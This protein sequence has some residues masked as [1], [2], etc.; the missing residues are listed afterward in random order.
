VNS[1]RRLRL[2]AYPEKYGDTGI[3]IFLINQ[4]GVLY[5][6]DL[7]SSTTETATSATGFS[8]GKTWTVVPK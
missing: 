4:D 5:D 7:G 2:H 6:K 3:A 1:D 8:P